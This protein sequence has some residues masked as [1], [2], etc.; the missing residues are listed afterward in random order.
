[1]LLAA[2]EL[3]QIPRSRATAAGT[4][5]SGHAKLLPAAARTQLAPLFCS[6]IVPFAATAAQ[7]FDSL[8]GQ[9]STAYPWFTVDMFT[10]THA[11]CVLL[12]SP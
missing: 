2:A 11:P 4:V 10:L 9:A 12:I 3:E 5:F 8:A 1:V 6:T 7:A